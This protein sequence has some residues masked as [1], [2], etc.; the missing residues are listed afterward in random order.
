[1]AP[2][3]VCFAI[4]TSLS[5]CR[6]NRHTLPHTLDLN[7]LIHGTI[8]IHIAHAPHPHPHNPLPNAGQSG[9]T[10]QQE[11]PYLEDFMEMIRESHE[12]PRPA[13]LSAAC[14]QQGPAALGATIRYG[15]VC[16]PGRLQLLYVMG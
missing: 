2:P 1:M 3:R 7:H 14:S 6:D 8:P 12:D 9:L 16:Q 5:H 13:L 11:A 4:A 15:H 10:A